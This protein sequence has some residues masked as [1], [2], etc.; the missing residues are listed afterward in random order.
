MTDICICINKPTTDSIRH[1]SAMAKRVPVEPVTMP[2]IAYI[3]EASN[4]TVDPIDQIKKE[5]QSRGLS[6][7]VVSKY[8]VFWGDYDQQDVCIV[9]SFNY[10]IVLCRDVLQQILDN[11]YV[12]REHEFKQHMPVKSTPF[13][14]P[15]LIFVS[16]NSPINA[17]DDDDDCEWF[18]DRLSCVI[19]SHTDVRKNIGDFFDFNKLST[20]K[21]SDELIKDQM[22]TVDGCMWQELEAGKSV[23]EVKEALLSSIKA[24]F[25][26]IRPVELYLGGQITFSFRKEQ[27]CVHFNPS[28]YRKRSADDLKSLPD[29]EHL[30][31]ERIEEL[32]DE[33]ERRCVQERTF[34]FQSME[35]VPTDP[36]S[37][38]PLSPTSCSERHF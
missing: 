19:M 36:S 21:K 14:S 22:F 11:K 35:S 23:Q 38:L 25:A 37:S 15:Y 32:I 9:Q 26:A 3:Y 20:K 17:Y 16:E 5:C 18:V 10:E 29:Y 31:D 7:C 4:T 27:L 6:Y 1:S 30:S 12:C 34:V 28:P 13:H 33:C 24:Y 8:P 2:Y